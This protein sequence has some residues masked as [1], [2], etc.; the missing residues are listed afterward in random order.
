MS[1][2]FFE[3]FTDPFTRFIT[4][5]G[6]TGSFAFVDLPGAIGELTT[7]TTAGNWYQLNTNIRFVDAVHN[8][9]FGAKLRTKESTN[10]E[11]FMGLADGEAGATG[12]AIGFYRSDGASPGNWKARVK[13]GGTGT[14]TDCGVVGG[15]NEVELVVQA[16]VTEVAFFLNGRLV[17]VATANIPL[18]PPLLL[19]VLWIKTNAGAARTLAVDYAHLTAAR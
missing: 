4:R 7:G 3:D 10:L 18:P 11:M 13:A 16:S 15:T 14:D 2:S 19:F 1:I 9:V 12:S 8:P 6:S 5:A 17:H